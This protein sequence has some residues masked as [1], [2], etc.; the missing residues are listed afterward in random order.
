VRDVQFT[1]DA[2]RQFKR[3]PKGTRALIKEAVRT[4]LL[5]ADPGQ[6]TRN[7]F[8]LRRISPF[9]DF[10]LR[11]GHW[12]VF[13]RLDGERVLVTLIGE[14]RGATLVVEGEELKL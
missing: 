14:K 7:K 6:A 13:Y 12:R 2:V 9:A 10:E 3:L 4:H 8:R 5:E 1:P 11:T